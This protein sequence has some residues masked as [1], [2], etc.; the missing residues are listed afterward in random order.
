METYQIFIIL[1]LIVVAVA[2]HSNLKEKSDLRKA[3]TGEDKERL[4]KLISQ[5]LPEGSWQHMAYAH[6]EKVEHFG[7]RTRTTYYCYALAYSDDSLW[8]IPLSFDKD[9]VIPSKPVQVTSEQLGMISVDTTQ[10]K[11]GGLKRV[12]VR[13][14][15]KEGKGLFDAYIDASNTRSD[16]FHHFNIVQQEECRHIQQFVD[17]FSDRVNEQ[18]EGLRERVEENSLKA[19]MKNARTVGII[20]LVL[21]FF[22]LL[23]II[24]GGVGLFVAPK[25]KETQGKATAPFILCLIS[26]IIGILQIAGFFLMI[27]L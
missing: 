21:F 26:L 12:A 8:I 15:D 5:V 20:G 11:D 7:R 17:S 14:H 18:N 27:S 13:L 25:P 10:N 23:P 9:I 2:L 16:R 3:E 22:P 6:W 19:R 24:F 4:R 1:V